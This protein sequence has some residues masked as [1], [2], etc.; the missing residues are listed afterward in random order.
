MKAMLLAVGVIVAVVGLFVYISRRDPQTRQVQEAFNI[1]KESSAGIPEDPAAVGY[2][3][4]KTRAKGGATEPDEFNQRYSADRAMQS[5]KQVEEFL[6]SFRKMTN[7]R[8]PRLSTAELAAIGNTGS[9]MQS[10]G[11][12]N[13]PLTVEGT[14][15]KQQYQ[16]TQLDYK[17]AQIKRIGGDM[18][19]GEFDKKR[20]AYAA[21]TKALQ[22]FWE[23]RPLAD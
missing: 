15:L 17:L 6:T 21:A 19:A 20:E 9:E 18:T 1:L 2:L 16:L 11:F 23:T 8:R 12:Q 14:I 4:L 3:N 10:I 7:L 5:I 22:T 13:F